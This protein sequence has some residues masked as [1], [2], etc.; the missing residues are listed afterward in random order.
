MEGEFTFSWRDP[1]EA[2][3]PYFRDPRK[4]APT[5]QQD[6]MPGSSHPTIRRRRQGSPHPIA[7]TAD[8]MA[9]ASRSTT[10]EPPRNDAKPRVAQDNIPPL[11]GM[12]PAIFVPATFDF[13]KPRPS[14]SSSTEATTAAAATSLRVDRALADLEDHMNAVKRNISTL[15]LREARRYQQEAAAREVMLA[16]AGQPPPRSKR[17]PP[18][19][20]D[21]EL[22][23][24]NL[25]AHS[26]PGRTYGVHPDFGAAS[27]VGV[28]PHPKDTPREAV[29]TQIL[30][31]I[32]Y[33]GYQL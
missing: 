25:A 33:G 26:V 1:V 2:N 17:L 18:T 24:Q 10:P 14:P 20:A 9:P 13:T 8:E 19:R 29:T 28:V 16:D 27:M 31:L 3:W 6:T 21:E 32:R 15:T 7:I 12:A 11:A 4:A 30:D 22:M 23:L 5:V